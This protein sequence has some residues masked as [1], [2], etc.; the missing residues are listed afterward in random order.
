MLHQFTWQHFLVAAS[1]LALAW[2]V[3]VIL[4]FYRGKVSALLGKGSSPLAENNFR[5]TGA[6]PERREKGLAPAGEVVQEESELMGRVKLPEGM[7]LVGAGD[8]GFVGD[9]DVE[10]Q[11]G[12]VPDLLAELR[13]VFARLV[14][15]DGG[16]QDFLLMM[17]GVREAYPKMASHPQIGRINE[18]ITDHAPFYLAPE[19]LENLWY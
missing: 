7:A 5:S 12:L 3:V 15:R 16:K 11:V 9:R 17:A 13:S 4:V 18:F 10:G 6:Q 1:V 2:Y 14:E 8:F 19:E